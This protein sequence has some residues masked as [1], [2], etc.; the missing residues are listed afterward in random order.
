M[1]NIIQWNIRGL[2]ANY[3]ELQ[4]L[5]NTFQPVA[6][7]LQELII[8]ESYKFLNRQ[9]SLL[10]KLPDL[11]INGRPAGGAG[12]MVRNDIPY[13]ELK[14]NSSLQA[15]ACRISAPEPISV[16]SVYLPP[17]SNRNHGDLS[18]LVAQLPSPVL[19]M[20]DFN[21]HST[22]WGCSSTNP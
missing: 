1:A 4:L 18:T 12:I 7:C 15:V 9:Y 11:D 16:C 14:L 3:S 17:T 19:V 5:I 10:T 13:S 22:L 6:L 21:S 20:G 2:R 8:P